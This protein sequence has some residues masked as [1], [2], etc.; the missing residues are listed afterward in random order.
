MA[1]LTIT[2]EER[3]AHSYLDWD[4]ASLG[5]AVKHAALAMEQSQREKDPDG[6]V[7]LRLQI[8][9]LLISGMMAES[10][11]ET[12][13]IETAGVTYKGKPVGDLKVVATRK[14]I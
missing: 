8:P 12:M 1:T 7:A 5:K 13:E 6:Y 10:N 2:D 4:D 11:A 14:S 3:E 9:A